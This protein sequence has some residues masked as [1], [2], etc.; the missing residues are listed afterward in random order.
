MEK[1]LWVSPNFNHYKARFLNHLAKT[2]NLELTVIAGSGVSGQGHDELA[3]DWCFKL[4]RLAVPKKRFGYTPKAVFAIIIL[5]KQFDWVMI[6]R[7]KKNSLLILL[8]HF[9]RRITF[10]RNTKLISYNHPFFGNR[11]ER[12]FNGGLLKFFYKVYDLIIFYNQKS[13]ELALQAG[14][15]DEYKVGWANNTLDNLEIARYYQFINPNHNHPRLLFI[16]RLIPSKRVDIA[17][18]YF[19]KLKL[20]IT[21][22]EL[23][24]VGDGPE[25]ST[26]KSLAKGVEGIHFHGAQNQEEILSNYFEQC[27]L[28]FIPGHTGLSINHAFLYGRGYITLD[29]EKHAPEIHYL[30][31]GYNG[32]LL[33][34][35]ELDNV[36]FL[37]EILT[38]KDELT[39]LS[40]NAMTSGENLSMENWCKQVIDSLQKIKRFNTK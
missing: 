37:K 31:E 5:F 18:N 23:D 2:E 30:D 15:I 20:S 39:R 17:I 9:Y 35:N 19:K 6:P 24:I 4:I 36:D 29:V 16:G 3:S 26:L 13:S 33:K 27:S 14:V 10:A 25:E 12:G 7:E 8:V 32:Y 22:L 34:G 11:L 38:N 1:V 28:V 21:N 40:K